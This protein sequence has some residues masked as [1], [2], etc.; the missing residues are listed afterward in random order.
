MKCW[1]PDEHLCTGDVLD[2][3]GHITPE[4]TQANRAAVLDG[5][6]SRETGG[7]IPT[8]AP[9][10]INRRQGPAP[11]SVTVGQEYVLLHRRLGAWRDV[12]SSS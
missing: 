5:S 2:H 9:G 4:A 12:V 8:G 6:F 7:S 10:T 11:P 1:G 3:W